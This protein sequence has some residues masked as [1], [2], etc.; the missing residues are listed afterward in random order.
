MTLLLR[1]AGTPP[2][3]QRAPCS[4]SVLTS[5]RRPPT[6]A[7][8]ANSASNAAS[9]ART[10]GAASAPRVKKYEWEVR[11]GV[12]LPEA[13]LERARRGAAAATTPAQRSGPAGEWEW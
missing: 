7:G 4:A 8:A 13:T 2:L 9:A 12:S 1:P 3:R 6:T 5:A 10:T 11:D